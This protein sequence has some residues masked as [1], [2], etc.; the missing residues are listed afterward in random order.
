MGPSGPVMRSVA[1]KRASS[2]GSQVI[3]QRSKESMLRFSPRSGLAGVAVGV[4]CALSLG[5]SVASAAP[6]SW[7]VSGSVVQ[8]G[9][10][11]LEV[12]GEAP[13]VCSDFTYSGA[14]SG[15][16]FFAAYYGAGQACDGGWIDTPTMQE[17][18]EESGGYFLDQLTFMAGWQSPWGVYAAYPH[19]LSFVN[20]SGAAP[21]RAVFDDAVIGRLGDGREIRATGELEVTTPEGG[22]V[23]L[24]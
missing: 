4:L 14:A 15:S 13:L 7:S 16:Y 21:S 23:T 18:R 2:H 19:T 9:S 8:S 22:A 3:D 6:A 1:P 11:T 5:V 24:D 10:V 17:A 20:G 12:E